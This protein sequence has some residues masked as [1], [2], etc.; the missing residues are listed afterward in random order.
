[1]TASQ[2]LAATPPAAA[3][4]YSL[5]LTTDAAEV[6]AAQR[7]RHRVFAGELGARLHSPEP[8]LDV[9]RFDA[10]C[11]HL[12]VR[13]DATG[14]IVGTYRML[15]P[16]RARDAGGL[17]AEDEFALDALAPL[18]DSLVETGRSCVHPDHRDGAVINLV[19][20]G[21]AR[22]MLLT[23]H[24]WLIGCA[25]VP[26]ADGGALAASVAARVRDG[27]LSPPDRRVTPHRPWTHDGPAVRAPL[28][29]LLRGYLRLGAQVCG[30]PAHDPDFG[31]ADFPV[32][33]GLDHMDPRYARFFL[34]EGA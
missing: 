9:D 15:P 12:V 27:H 10:H 23:G 6:R 7:L 20:A 1:M 2:L 14:E 21:I 3:S 25:S 28:P 16:A 31:C 32:L 13:E 29:P 22:Y 8:G 5:L 18:R 33:L 24:R 4:R 17:Y 34:G 19:W 11:D 30:A 26:L